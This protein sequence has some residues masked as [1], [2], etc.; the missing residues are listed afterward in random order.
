MALQL[1]AIGVGTLVLID[2]DTV[3]PEN[4]ASQGFLE[5]NLG[6]L[7]V[8]AVGELCSK[9]NSDIVI[10]HEPEKFMKSVISKYGPGTVFVCVDSMSARSFIWKT[11]KN[12]SVMIVDGRMAAE[13][14]RV[15]TVRSKKDHAHYESTLFSDEEAYTG[16]CT[17]KT[18]LYCANVAAGLMVAQLPKMFRGI[19]YDKDMQFNILANELRFEKDTTDQTPAEDT[20]SAA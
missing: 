2:F 4:L 11:C 9:I 6:Q 20:S 15:L 3:D 19:P 8:D 14:C 10:A 18:T 13:V 5:E 1:A 7:K 12:T 16:T 17:A